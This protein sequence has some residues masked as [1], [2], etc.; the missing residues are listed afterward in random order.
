MEYQDQ[1]TSS[2][3]P[4][5]TTKYVRM[6]IITCCVAFVL[7]IFADRLLIKVFALSLGGISKLYIWQPLTYIFLHGGAW[8]LFWNMLIFYFVGG[9]VEYVLGSK[10][11]IKL[12]LASGIIA[13]LGWLTISFFTNT[14]LPC[15]GASGAVYGILC[16]FAGMFPDRTITLLVLLV[17]PVTMKARTLALGIIAFSALMMIDQSGGVAHSA[18]LFGAVV[19]YLYGLRIYKNPGLLDSPLYSQ[20]SNNPILSWFSNIRAKIRRSQFKVV[21]HDEAPPTQQEIDR[22]LDKVNAQGMK[23]LTIRERQVLRRAS[24]KK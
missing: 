18:H 14:Y 16:C 23:S 12:F 1:T 7:Q 3:K 9:E 22:V 13:G 24:D 19:G 15:L 5:G 2:F 20:S 6:I 11:F 8:H 17:F 10:R 4:R 21:P